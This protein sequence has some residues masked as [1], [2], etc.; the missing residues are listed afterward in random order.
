ARPDYPRYEPA[1]QPPQI[2]SNYKEE[3]PGPR[4]SPRVDRTHPIVASASPIIAWPREPQGPSAGRRSHS[5]IEFP[6]GA[7]LSPRQE[8][9]ISDTG[10]RASRDAR[11]GREIGRASCRERGE[12][13][14]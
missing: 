8:S 4:L 2:T 11:G 12:M 14:G 9:G 10:S 5:G 6:R 1:D 3:N 13:W 7:P